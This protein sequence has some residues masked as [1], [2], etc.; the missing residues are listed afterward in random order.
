MQDKQIVEQ[1]LTLVVVGGNGS[2]NI[3]ENIS[4]DMKSI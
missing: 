1:N 3:A 2:F 4:M